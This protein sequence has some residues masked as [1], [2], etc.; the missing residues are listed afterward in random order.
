LDHR[1]PPRRRSSGDSFFGFG[2]ALNFGP[3]LGW[4]PAQ[5]EPELPSV[6]ELR[7]PPQQAQE[8]ERRLG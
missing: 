4:E 8:W 3:L 6:Q 7:A 2:E 1:A 5:P